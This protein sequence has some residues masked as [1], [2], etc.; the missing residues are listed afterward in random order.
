MAQLI[1]TPSISLSRSPSPNPTHMPTSEYS[2]RMPD[3]PRVDMP[4]VY[5]RGSAQ[6]FVVGPPVHNPNPELNVDFL[7]NKD[8]GRIEPIEFSTWGYDLRHQGQS[9]LPFL[10]VAPMAT[11]R[12]DEFLDDN[13]IT[14]LVG[15][16]PREGAAIFTAGVGKVAKSRGIE[17]VVVSYEHSALLIQS[18]AHTNFIINSHLSKLKEQAR[19]VVYCHSGN[20]KSPT[21]IAAYLMETFRGMNNAEQAMSVVLTR[22]F[23]VH[24]DEEARRMLKAY[25]DIISARSQVLG[26]ASQAGGIMIHRHQVLNGQTVKPTLPYLKR[27]RDGMLHNVADDYW[28]DMERFGGREFAPFK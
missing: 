4:H 17:H 10:F 18:F 20:E 15:I 11:C 6:P 23:C 2:L 26:T 9:I 25:E 22:R 24:F 5:R 28:E 3:M 7:N 14:L 8:Y 16:H 19:M 13:G 1:T 27:S 12:R 21:F